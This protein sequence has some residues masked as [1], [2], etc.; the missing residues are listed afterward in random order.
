L[1]FDVGCLGLG[2]RKPVLEPHRSFIVA[3]LE[4]T[5]HLTLHG[6]KAELAARGL[7]FK[8][9]LFDLEQTRADVARRR[10]W[11]DY[12]C[13]VADAKR[14]VARA[15]WLLPSSYGSEHSLSPPTAFNFRSHAS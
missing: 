10:S 6:L 4:Q 1:C 7:R 9:T 15:A 5:S 8:K 2:H 14:H 11:Q 3:G 13:I 12:I